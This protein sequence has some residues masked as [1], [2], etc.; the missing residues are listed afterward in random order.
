MTSIGSKQNNK[1]SNS[2]QRTISIL[3][4][5]RDKKSSLL[6]YEIIQH[7]RK[8]FK[9]KVFFFYIILIVNV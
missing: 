9:M 1:R 2:K 4:R 5:L 8:K 6:E 3:K 7:K